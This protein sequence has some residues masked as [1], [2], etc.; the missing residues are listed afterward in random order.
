MG[1]VLAPRSPLSFSE[2]DRG[3]PAPAPLLGQHTDE[4]LMD[5]L[6]MTSPEVGK[7]HDNGIVAAAIK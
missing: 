6:G 1:R 5:V 2:I 4:I 7:L 3:D